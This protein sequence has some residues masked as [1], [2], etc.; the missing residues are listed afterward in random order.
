MGEAGT[1]R[2]PASRPAALPPPCAAE[3]G[4]GG[5]GR[6]E[7][8]GPQLY[9]LC[10]VKPGDGCRRTTLHTALGA[11]LIDLKQTQSKLVQ[12]SVGLGCMLHNANSIRHQWCLC[13]VFRFYEQFGSLMYS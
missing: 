3:T 13:V 11:A 9:T 1:A 2:P 6:H 4:R 8:P 12:K 7:T 5:P 10:T